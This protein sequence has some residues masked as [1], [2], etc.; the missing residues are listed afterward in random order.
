ML[1]DLYLQERTKEQACTCWTLLGVD[2]DFQFLTVNKHFY[3][4]RNDRWRA[5]SE[6]DD[7]LLN[8]RDHHLERRLI[9]QLGIGFPS[10]PFSGRQNREGFE[11]DR[12]HFWVVSPVLATVAAANANLLMQEFVFDNHGDTGEEN[13][14]VFG[15]SLIHLLREKSSRPD[16][17][18]ILGV[19]CNGGRSDSDD[20]RGDPLCYFFGGLH[21]VSIFQTT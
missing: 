14:F 13:H 5:G 19:R 6:G 11:E 12:E 4:F 8:G 17:R 2:V 1:R 21:R 15:G 20:A 3:Q 18:A 9:L 7:R 10:L 16:S